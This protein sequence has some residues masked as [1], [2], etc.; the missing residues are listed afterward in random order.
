MNEFDFVK[1]LKEL[2]ETNPEGYNLVVETIHRLSEK[3]NERENVE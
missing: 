2:Q 3:Q 1:A